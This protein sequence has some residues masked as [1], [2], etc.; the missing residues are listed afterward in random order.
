MR[1]IAID[2]ENLDLL[3]K[4]AK[5]QHMPITRLVD[6][7]LD[8]AL[9]FPQQ[10]IQDIY[11]EMIA[12][13]DKHVIRCNHCRRR[14]DPEDFQNHVWSIRYRVGISIDGEKIPLWR[15]ARERGIRRVRVKEKKIVELE[16]IAKRWNMP[17]YILA[18]MLMNFSLTFSQME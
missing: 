9:E 10:G 11:D 16:R 4:V 12:D 5:Q 15:E 2:R 6:I 17:L 3:Q 13:D 7:L 8:L 18:N 1:R 14:F